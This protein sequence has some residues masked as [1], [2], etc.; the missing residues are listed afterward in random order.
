MIIN[1]KTFSGELIDYEED[2][3]QSEPRK[4]KR[5]KTEGLKYPCYRCEY[6]ATNS[7][8][9][10]LHIESKHEGV[11]YTCDKCEYAANT[12]SSLK[13]HIESQHEGVRYPCDK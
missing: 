1:L 10:K 5:S 2:T 3:L 11:R 4:I 12:A 7:S 9:L 6:S 8:L 13:R